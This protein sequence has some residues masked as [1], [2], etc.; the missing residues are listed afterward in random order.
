MQ[1]LQNLIDV[2]AVLKS[3][4][5]CIVADGL[6]WRNKQRTVL[7]LK[8]NIVLAVPTYFALVYFPLR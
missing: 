6:Y 2:V 8:V 1:F 7:W 4:F 3:N 5:D